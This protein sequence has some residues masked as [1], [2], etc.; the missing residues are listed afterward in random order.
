[1]RLFLSALCAVYAAQVF[2]AEKT[3]IDFNYKQ[4]DILKVI[5]DYAK[6]SGQKFIV[7]PGVR[8]RITITNS[9]P[10]TLP[11]AYNQMSLALALNSVGISKQEDV[12][13]VNESRNIQRDLI[14][15]GPELPALK[16]EKM[17]TWVI[18]LKYSSA[19]EINKQL[20]ILTSKDGELVPYVRTNQILVTDW[21]SNLYRIAKII[22]EIDVPVSKTAKVEKKSKT[23]KE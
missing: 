22:K 3:T 15:V 7:A 8:A 5:E 19:D 4:V 11:E 1:M 2:A 12:S 13:V 14:D 10:V 9:G 16:P 23:E 6:A 17:F 18:N 20:R 21:V